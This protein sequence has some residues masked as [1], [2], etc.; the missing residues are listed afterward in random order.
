MEMASTV[1]AIVNSSDCAESD[2]SPA[3]CVRDASPMEPGTSSQKAGRKVTIAGRLPYRRSTRRVRTSITAAA[4]PLAMTL[5]RHSNDDMISF[6]TRTPSGFQIEFGTG[7]LLID[8]SEW[9][10]PRFD[11]PSFWGHVRV[12]PAEADVLD[13]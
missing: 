13:T 10:P 5:G 12:N 8:D 3:N 9:L 4:A 11:V 6:Y 2:A 7:G 1:A